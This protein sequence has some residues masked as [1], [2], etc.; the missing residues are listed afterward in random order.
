[1]NE[2]AGWAL[3]SQKFGANAAWLRLN[4][5][6]YNLL[7]A[8]KRVGLPEDLREARP[9][10]LRF[11]VSTRSERSSATPARPS[12]ASPTD[13]ARALADAP[14]VILNLP[15][16]PSSRGLRALRQQAGAAEQ[17][18]L[19]QEAVDFTSSV[20]RDC[21]IPETGPASGSPDCVGAQY[22]GQRSRWVARLSGPASEEA[23]RP[24]ERHIALQR[25]L[26]QLG[27]LPP[28]ATIDGVYGPSTRTAMSAWQGN[29]G[30]PRTTASN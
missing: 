13:L 14:R 22:N 28:T 8:F 19:Q 1:M 30:R 12:C 10:R 2:L 5:L 20:L 17:R 11:L 9:K 25:D 3:P 24:I 18:Q 23:D 15:T 16:T 26:W 4:A 6:L 7:S 27:Y 21:G 29:R